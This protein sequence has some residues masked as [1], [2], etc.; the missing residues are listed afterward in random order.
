MIMIIIM[1]TVLGQFP[2]MSFVADITYQ[3][4]IAVIW[5]NISR[6]GNKDLQKL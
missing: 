3:E 1:I 5:E 2:I 4:W 6:E